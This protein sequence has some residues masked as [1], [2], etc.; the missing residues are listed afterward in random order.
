MNEQTTNRSLE[1][2]QTIRSTPEPR[3]PQ[4]WPTLSVDLS[5]REQPPGPGRG[6]LQVLGIIGEG[7][8]G[9][10]LLAR[11]HSLARDVAVKTA[12][13]EG[14]AGYASILFEGAITG[15][16]E[17]PAIVPVHALGLDA[18]G[19]PGI[20]M[21]RIEGVAWNGLLEDPA[22][23]GWDG[24]EGDA[25]N[26]L[27]GHLQILAAVCNALH[28]AHSRGVVHLDVKPQNVLIGRFGDVYVADWG[29]ARPLGRVNSGL[30]G[31]PA[32]L[33]PELA[34]PGAV[35]D[36]R[37]DVYLLG[38]TLHAV[39]TGSPRHPGASV[40]DSLAHARGSPAFE[41]PAAVPAELGALANRACHV[42]PAQRPVSARAFREELTAWVRHRDAAALAQQ[43]ERRVD[44]LEQLG[45]H[46][47]GGL[48]QRTQASRLLFEARFGLE[49]SLAQWP[50]NP[51]AKAALAR[52]EAIVAAQQ[53]RALQLEAEALERD[54]L[55]GVPWRTATLAFMGLMA[56]FAYFAAG[57]VEH[58]TPWMLV[59]VPG[60]VLVVM[61]LGAW[62][63]R[64]KLLVNQFNR[65]VLAVVVIGMAAMVG[66]R[67]LA[68]FA[69][70]TMGELFTRDALVQAGVMAVC[71]VAYLRWVWIVAALFAGF[72]V[73]CAVF[74]EQ[75]LT[76]FGSATVAALAVAT[77]AS[78]VD[79]R[80]A[81]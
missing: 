69:P 42:D 46:P 45:R 75:A 78:W 1:N 74:P 39:L 38:A 54:P 52:V 70:V 64:A 37:T 28:F 50:E 23:P 76:L 15:Q 9:R 18:S 73:A 13:D 24:W 25:T 10:V 22:H 30:C 60:A 44:E 81:A 19:R 31:T 6:D 26:R 41:Y 11:Q 48:D 16:L 40:T 77:V 58:A 32:Y 53:R 57:V 72:G 51:T 7:G 61:V 43:A 65:Q 4:S 21:K 56:A 47:P 2:D 20:V 36:A 67:L 63:L 29:I 68:V 49:Q 35:L 17:H 14:E 3:A 33:A 27:A 5:G 71:A 66:S 80:R 34:T 79:Q 12:R 62:A 8:A 59:A 55:R